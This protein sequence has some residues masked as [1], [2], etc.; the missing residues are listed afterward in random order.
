MIMCFKSDDKYGA[1][2]READ[3]QKHRGAENSAFK[4]GL[5]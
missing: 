4:K 1:S 3:E 2:I 5:R